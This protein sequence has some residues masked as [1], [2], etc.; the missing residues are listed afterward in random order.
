MRLFV[1]PLQ[2]RGELVQ[3]TSLYLQLPSIL[4][5]HTELGY[6]TELF[7]PVL[8]K[9]VLR[10]SCCPL[11]DSKSMNS[12]IFVF[13]VFILSGLV[14]LS[15]KLAGC[16]K[17]TNLGFLCAEFAVLVVFRAVAHPVAVFA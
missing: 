14:W 9:S 16:K 17:Y 6:T 1:D 12:A 5:V 4:F 3:F 15:L 8:R 13:L 10:L 7:P 11:A 2:A